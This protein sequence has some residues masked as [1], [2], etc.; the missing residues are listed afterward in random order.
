MPDEAIRGL[1]AKP[2]TKLPDNSRGAWCSFSLSLSGKD[3]ADVR[4]VELLDQDERPTGSPIHLERTGYGWSGVGH[5]AAHATRFR[6][7]SLGT[8]AAT[9]PLSDSVSVQTLPRW[10]AALR[11][12]WR[13]RSF[14]LRELREGGS[15]A[16]A[17]WRELLAQAVS[18]DGSPIDYQRWVACFDVWAEA[19][20]KGLA[21]G[22]Q[23]YMLVYD[24]GTAP[25]ALAATL[26]SLRSNAVAHAVV[27]AGSW[28]E[29]AE[30]TNARHFGLL[31]PGEVL[32]PQALNILGWQ[33]SRLGD[34][35]MACCDEDAL[36][37]A[38]RRHT[39][40][41]K[42]MANHPLMLS[43]T[44][45]RG[46]W[47]VRRDILLSAPLDI[48]TGH[49][50]TMRLDLWLRLHEDGVVRPS[51]RIPYVLTHRRSDAS[52][53]PPH[54]LAGV[55]EAHLR[56]AGIDWRVEPALPLRVHPA[57]TGPRPTVS[58]IVPSALRAAHVTQCVAKVMPLTGYHTVSMLVAV[59]Q[60]RPLDTQQQE[61][62]S[63]IEADARAKV[64]W[65]NSTEFNYSIVNNRAAACTDG[66]I[67][68]LLNDDVVPTSPNWLEYLVMHFADPRV[69]VVG[70]RLLYP[71]GQV[72]HGGI[73]MGMDTLAN[74]LHRWEPATSPGYCHRGVL[75]HEVSG[76]TGACLLVRRRVFDALGGLDPSYASAFNDVDFC[77]R[78]REAGHAVVYSGTKSL[79]HFEG[80]T[81][82]QHYSGPTAEREA[83]DVAQMRMRWADAIKEDPFHSP[84]LARVTRR[85][86]MPAFPP[87]LPPVA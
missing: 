22:P 43:G 31:A 35:E 79:L 58:I 25:E 78:V 41:F 80:K 85:E 59:A 9:L 16:A 63:R 15:G 36:D 42:P 11:L 54:L 60:P 34:P 86:W 75:P 45:T 20:F 27:D 48:A 46:L 72:Q 76:V 57:A 70:A 37:A 81:Y 4:K 26:A 39:P 18:Y 5:V 21:E 7:C 19:E 8:G 6:L 28:R 61:V 17:Q 3:K 33:L 51:E 56:R 2:A 87:R 38:G 47:I 67:L 44:L 69:G 24:D 53:A 71:D 49:A 50:E 74:H 84:N 73:L 10:T 64:L 29:A 13:S 1:I 30:G 66:E 40:V 55:V 83:I 68:C 23:P 12:A 14:L 82:G 32:A 62:A 52:E 65:L 77:L